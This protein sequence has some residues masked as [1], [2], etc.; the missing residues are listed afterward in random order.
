MRISYLHKV[1]IFIILFYVSNISANTNKPEENISFITLADLHFDPFYSCEKTNKRC[2]IIDKLNSHPVS[3]WKNIFEQENKEKSIYK[4]DTNYFLFKSLLITLKERN[5]DERPKFVLLLGDLLA[6]NY[7]LNYR[8]YTSDFSE[9]KLKDF[10]QKT[11][12]FMLNQLKNTFPGVDIYSVVGNNDSYTHNNSTPDFYKDTAKIWSQTIRKKEIRIK[13]K[14]DFSKNGGYY[15]LNISKNI[16]LIILNTTFFAQGLGL[17]EEAKLEWSWLGRELAFAHERQKKVIIG[18]HIP[19][20]VDAYTSIIKN[21]TVTLWNVSDTQIFLNLLEKYGAEII[22]IFS[23]HLHADCYNLINFKRKTKKIPVFGIPS[24]SPLYGNNP[25]FKVFLYSNNSQEMKKYFTYYY[26]LDALIPKWKI[27]YDS[28]NLYKGVSYSNTLV[29][30]MDQI[31][32]KGELA[33]Y[34][35]YFYML[36]K[37]SQPISKENNWLLYFCA[38][39]NIMPQAYEN[40]IKFENE[41]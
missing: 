3:E 27:A 40:C 8:K 18:L 16:R 36:G 39:R 12:Q 24:I 15:A 41:T 23:G 11:I 34:Y 32:K 38:I 20:S 21:K 33:S 7:Q 4:K 28:N 10:I 14:N 17:S 13:I 9:E 22:A 25:G 35:K 30:N 2:S 26:H 29:K 1:M 6:H 31:D 37:N 5:N 19:C